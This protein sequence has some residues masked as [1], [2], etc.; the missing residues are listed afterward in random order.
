LDQAFIN[1]HFELFFQPVMEC[2]SSQ[3]V[4]HHK[5]ISRLRDGHGEALP[6]GRFLPWLER[7]GWMPRLDV[8]VLEKVLAHL[9]GHDQV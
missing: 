5:V 9:R 7:F 6:A 1:G 4:L 2:A 3:R 8:L